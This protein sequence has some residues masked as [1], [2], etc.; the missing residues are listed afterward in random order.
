M[1]HDHVFASPS[2]AASVL[3]GANYNGRTAWVDRQSQKLK[4]HQI[5][6]TQTEP[7]PATA[8]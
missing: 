7:T 4:S 6:S 3:A 8:A 5:V 2:A 1:T